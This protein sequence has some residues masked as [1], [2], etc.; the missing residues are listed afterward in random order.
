MDVVISCRGVGGSGGNLGELKGPC[1]AGGSEEFYRPSVT[2]YTSL[3]LF[4]SSFR[5]A[6]ELPC[7]PSALALAVG[8]SFPTP[9]WDVLLLRSSSS[10]SCCPE[11]AAPRHWD[12]LQPRAR[13][14]GPAPRPRCPF[15][16]K[17]SRVL[18]GICSPFCAL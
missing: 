6:V 18:N 2:F 11:A 4:L 7:S 16:T 9:P 8:R 14:P 13:V 5:R 10:P 12:L 15:V 1:G 3:E 17:F